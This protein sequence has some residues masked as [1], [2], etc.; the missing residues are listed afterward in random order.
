MPIKGM[1]DSDTPRYVHLG[2]LRKGG[3]KP[4]E[5]KRPGQDLDHFRVTFAPQFEMY[6]EIFA[7]MYGDKPTEFRN[8]YVIGD[9]P[10]QAFP[11]Y[12]MEFNG[13]NALIRHCDGEHIDTWMNGDGKYMKVKKLCERDMKP[14]GCQCK[15]T[16]LLK[17]VFQD[18]LE[19]TG[20][21]GY[22]LATTHSK[23]DILAI[24]GVLKGY[25]AMFGGLAGVRFV[26]GRNKQK[27]TRPTCTSI[28]TS[29]RRTLSPRSRLH[30]SSAR[31][32]VM[33][34]VRW[35]CPIA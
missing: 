12:M 8:V 35:H 21:F 23:H 5:G 30:G 29:P 20:L 31:R 18:F 7:E 16:G 28:P 25:S 15:E 13:S 1:T 14:V 17:L 26:F 33:A 4:V 32:W 24:D 34:L 11:N 22:F 10:A 3:E 19:E 9:T 27:I 2:E 6:S